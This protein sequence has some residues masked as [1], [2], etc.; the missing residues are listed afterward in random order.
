MY[1]AFARRVTALATLPVLAALLPAASA[2]AAPTAGAVEAEALA[3]PAASGTTYA[4][5]T[6]SGGRELFLWSPDSARG[7]VTTSVQA[8]ALLVT[9]RGD[10]CLGAPQAEVTVDG[11][12]VG[13]LTVSAA[14]SWATYRVTGSWAAGSHSV[15]VRYVNDVRGASCDRNLHLDALSFEAAPGATPVAAPAPAAPTAVAPGSWTTRQTT[16]TSPVTDV[17][18]AVWSPATG[19][20]GGG[21][22]PVWG[23][24]AGSASEALYKSAR[25]GA[26]SW[27]VTVPAA[28]RYAV[29]LLLSDA[30]G[31][32]P[33]DRVFDVTA[34]DGNGAPVAIATGVD[35][36]A[37]ARGWWAYH[38]TGVVPVTS[39][40]LTLRF[41]ARRGQTL[42]N[43]LQVTTAGP[44]SGGGTAF[45]DEFEGAAGSAPAAVWG[46]RVGSGPWGGG[47]LQAYTDSRTNSALDG[48]GRLVLTARKERWA[49]QWGA[50]GYTSARLETKGRLTFTYGRVEARMQVPAG[51]GL[52]PAFWALGSDIDAVDWPRCGE[53]DVM[54]YLGGQPTTVYG[55]L[56]GLGDAADKLGW[57]DQRVS[58]VGLGH[59]TGA[60]LAEGMHTY[61]MDVTPNYVTFSVDGRE[62]FTATRADMRSGQQWPVGKP[63]YL[64]LNL[65][66]GG[67]WGGAPD[68]S[69]AFPASL[70]VDRVSISG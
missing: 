28:A 15:A 46:R 17:T 47:E 33:G 4:D 3:L 69:T 59:D 24:I 5:P 10:Q 70:V 30:T 29:D 66:V 12:V 21:Q 14:G 20:S 7:T 54:E 42:V 23:G 64:I 58:D 65:A 25:Q 63:Y 27:T 9:A 32:K 60:R 11:R 61:A 43:A 26:T 22:V 13:T 34:A 55:H 40:K 35:I 45:T 6:A 68:A 56:H 2:V 18:G 8:A 44:L 41:V 48:N 57:R 38:V 31:A 16:G 51:Q 52:W 50:Q 19:L 36:V 53:L 39:G 1:P 37:T 62:Y 49:D 67:D